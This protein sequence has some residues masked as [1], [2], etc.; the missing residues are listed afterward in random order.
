MALPDHTR[1]LAER[2]FAAYCEGLCAPGVR[3]RVELGFR[4]EADGA[5]L[6]EQRPLCGVA[7][8]A[9]PVAIARL[10]Y[11]AGSGDWTLLCPVDYAAARP[12]WRRYPGL[13]PDRSVAHLLRVIDSD[14]DGHFFPRLNGAS[15][16]WCTSKGR[17]AD[18]ALRY[19]ATLGAP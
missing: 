8:A 19:R 3:P 15:L 5:V 2:L 12:R 18:C 7:G 16:R 4:L 9:R 6:F 14:P 1:R 10:G 11:A 13:L 17:C